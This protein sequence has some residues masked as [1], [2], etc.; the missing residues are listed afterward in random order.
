[1]PIANASHIAVFIDFT[2]LFSAS[3]SGTVLLV[4]KGQILPNHCG[5]LQKR[6]TA[7]AARPDQTGCL[8]KNRGHMT[9]AYYIWRKPR[10]LVHI[11]AS[12]PGSFAAEFRGNS[13]GDSSKSFRE[14]R[15]ENKRKFR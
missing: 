9:A 5:K 15:A 12:P 10:N 14:F 7:T 13:G 8:W 3:H 6:N 1:M 2:Q 11:K 4:S